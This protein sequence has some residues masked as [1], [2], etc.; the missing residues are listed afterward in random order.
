MEVAKAFGSNKL[1]VV[2]KKTILQQVMKPKDWV[3]LSILI[4]FSAVCWI[5]VLNAY[6]DSITLDGVVS[7]NIILTP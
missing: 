1:P 2:K 4:L 5:F 3:F 7:S 6:Q